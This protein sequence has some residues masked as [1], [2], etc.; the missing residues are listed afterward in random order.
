MTGEINRTVTTERLL[1]AELVR[2]A[3]TL[4]AGL[5]PEVVDPAWVIQLATVQALLGLYWELRSGT[6]ATPVSTATPGGPPA[7]QRQ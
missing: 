3:E 6:T 1:G 5:K 2:A 4:V 7:D